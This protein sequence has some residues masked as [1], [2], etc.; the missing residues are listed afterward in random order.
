MTVLLRHKFFVAAFLATS[1]AVQPSAL[2]SGTGKTPAS[3]YWRGGYFGP[4]FSLYKLKN[5]YD[6]TIPLGAQKLKANGKL[7]G[8]I[9]GYNFLEK[10]YMWGIE[11]DISN[12]SVFKD[13][14]SFMATLR[15]RI[16]K[17]V[18]YSLPF[19][20]GGIAVAGLNAKT[21]TSPL[22]DKSDAQLGLVV[23]AGFEQVLANA[24]TGRLEY[25]YGRFFSNGISARSTLRLKS[26]HMLRAS[27]A[28]HFRD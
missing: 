19:L 11:G 20:T 26:L 4:A 3:S 17:P 16:G 5:T 18:K 25:T 9:G 8:I 15:G 24:I 27:I 1:L 13:D 14:L 28:I 10:D 12:G 2:A 7:I 22:S 21:L 6:P 23:G